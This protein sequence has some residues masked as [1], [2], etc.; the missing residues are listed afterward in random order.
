MKYHNCWCIVLRTFV[1]LIFQRYKVN[2]VSWSRPNPDM[3]VSGDEVGNLVIWDVKTNSTRMINVGKHNVFVLEC[4]PF[5]PD[6]V[7]FGCKLGL[8]LIVNIQG[9]TIIRLKDEDKEGFFQM[10]FPYRQWKNQT[11][12]PLSR[13]R[14]S[15]IELVTIETA[16]GVSWW[17]KDSEGHKAN[18]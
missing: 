5:A 4:H 3:V 8:V 1:H 16:R 14:C 15:R 2:T 12:D 9:K 6:V 18:T 11:E 13:R 17:R 7:A 10:S